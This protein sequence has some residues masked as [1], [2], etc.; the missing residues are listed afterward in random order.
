MFRKTL[1]LVMLRQKDNSRIAVRGTRYR[2]VLGAQY[3]YFKHN[4]V[5]LLQHACLISWWKA[6]M[7]SRGWL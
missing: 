2:L 5:L 4:A 7:H 3:G 6:F 1:V